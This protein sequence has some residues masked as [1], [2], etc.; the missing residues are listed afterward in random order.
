M[1]SRPSFRFSI[2]AIALLL[3]GSLANTS[4][5]AQSV[6]VTTW[7]ND[8]SRT[9]RNVSETILTP[10][11][12]NSSQFG[13]LFSY[14]VDGQIYAQP[15]YVP[16]VSIPRLGVFNVLY[17]ATEHDSVYAFDAGGNRESPLWH[18]NFT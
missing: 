8:N 5:H 3:T 9:G 6:S 15:L 10:S 11:N 18:V 13:K 7:H 17:I 4:L 1:F 2:A 16:N 14:K 12:V